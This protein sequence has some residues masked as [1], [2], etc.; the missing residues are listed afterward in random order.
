MAKSS[1]ISRPTGGAVVG[2][3]DIRDAAATIADTMPP[4]P[5]VHSQVLS[6]QAGCEI[7]LKL[8]NLRFTGSFKDRGA[9]VKL[10]SLSKSERRAG[11]IAMSAGNHA[12]GVAFNARH[13]GIPATIVMPRGTPFTKIR[14]TETLGAEVV[15]AGETLADAAEHAEKL[16]KER[17][18]TFVHPYDDPR[19]IAGQ[20]TIA[21]EILDREPGIDQIVVPIGGGGLISGIAIAG[22]AVAPGIE[23]IGAETKLYPSM[24]QA[25]R[26]EKPTSGGQT[27]ADGIAVKN[28][29]KLTRAII[30]RLVDDIIL[31]DETE[32]EHAV[33]RFIDVEKT[34]VEG[35]GAVSLAAVFAEE[36]RF[37]GKRVAVIV[38]GGNIDARVL[39]SILMR[40]LVR[41]GRLVR[42][43]VE[44]SDAPGA[45]AEIAQLVGE[46]RGNI[47]EIYHQRLFQDVPV[48][49]A[50]LDIVLETRDRG[51]VDE[52]V[53]ALR[54][55]GFETR[56]LS[57]M[58]SGGGS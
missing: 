39:A 49:L 42:L 11:V 2:I 3:D 32:I 13:L 46:H 41:E 22:K 40:G 52:I 28:P 8:E 51:H 35:A 24:H 58:A 25:L 20:G 31:V 30:E 23:I 26:G 56:H 55:A 37:A 19:I 4:T 16:Q 15:V 1:T 53:T 47:V 44:I 54:R 14:G 18:L 5:L 12:Q 6:R 45:L 27:I 48:K 50:E 36:H 21:L 29:G 9:L 43:R 57:S 17:G 33:Q 34:V 7:W 38:S 10:T